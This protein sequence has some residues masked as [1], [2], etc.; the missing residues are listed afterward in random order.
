MGLVKIAAENGNREGR[1]V[2]TRIYMI[3]HGEPFSTRGENGTPIRGWILRARP[4]RW[5]P[6]T[7]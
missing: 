6:Q 2:M 7:P 1:D 3:R 5:R 4:R